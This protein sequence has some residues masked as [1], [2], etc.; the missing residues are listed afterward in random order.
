MAFDDESFLLGAK[1]SE[2]NGLQLTSRS[3]PR[4][5]C[6][7]HTAS[8][9]SKISLGDSNYLASASSDAVQMPHELHWTSQSRSAV[10]SDQPL[11]FYGLREGR[12]AQVHLMVLPVHGVAPVEGSD[13]NRAADVGVRAADASQPRQ[14]V[15]G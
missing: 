13:E 7:D 15:T 2:P 14:A 4:R 6:S 8:R 11:A 10:R 12:M 5:P 1:T 9:A 3:K